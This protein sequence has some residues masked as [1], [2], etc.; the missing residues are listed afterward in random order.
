MAWNTTSTVTH[1]QTLPLLKTAGNQSNN[2]FINFRTGMIILRKMIYEGW[3]HVSQHFINEKGA[4]MPERLDAVI[5]GEG[6][7]TGY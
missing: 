5:S 6:K 3:T 7:I 1:H 2:I 4:S